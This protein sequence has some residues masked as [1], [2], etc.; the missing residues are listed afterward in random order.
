RGDPRRH[1]AEPLKSYNVKQ[2]GEWRWESHRDAPGQATGELVGPERDLFNAVEFVRA[3][4]KLYRSW[5]W[6]RRS[7][8]SVPWGSR[9]LY[10][11]RRHDCSNALLQRVSTNH[12]SCGDLGQCWL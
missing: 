5:G 4:A 3:G 12:V 1:V 6:N 10:A 8:D 9:S 11:E 7:D 2:L